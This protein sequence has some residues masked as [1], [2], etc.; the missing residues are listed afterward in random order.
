MTDEDRAK[1]LESGLV[2]LP[3]PTTSTIAATATSTVAITAAATTTSIVPYNQTTSIVP[4]DLTSEPKPDIQ[5]NYSNGMAAFCLDTIISEEDRTAAIQR[6][7]QKYYKGKSLNE[8]VANWKRP[9]GGKWFAA[10]EVRLG[11]CILDKV[12]QNKQDE[13]KKKKDADAKQ[14]AKQRE[15]DTK[16]DVSC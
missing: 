9:S 4:P 2:I 5:L 6:N 13:L 7:K 14:Q 10:G 12:K 8:K 16:Q 1:E 3:T 15:V 11:Q